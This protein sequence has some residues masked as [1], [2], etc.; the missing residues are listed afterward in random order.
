[1]FFGRN[2]PDGYVTDE[3][4]DSF[5]DVLN[6]TFNSYTVADCQGVWQGEDECTKY[7]TVSTKHRD[8]V[9]DVCA[10]YAKAFNQ[11]AVGLLVG[12]PMQFV[13]KLSEIY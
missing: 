13:S 12:Y 5:R 11:D 3:Q 10:A 8:K 7:V 2:T 9:V 1:M 4:W 6:M